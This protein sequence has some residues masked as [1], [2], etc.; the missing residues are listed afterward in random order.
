VLVVV[1]AALA[2]ALAVGWTLGLQIATLAHELPRY[3]ANITKKI[4][5]IKAVQ[6]GSLKDVQDSAN[7]VMKE[8]QKGG[9]GAGLKDQPVP[10]TVVPSGVIQWLPGIPRLTASMG[11]VILLVVF[12]LIRRLRL[13]SR[14]IV[15]LGHS[16]LT[17]TT[18]A[19]DEAGSRIS[20]YLLMQALM[21]GSLGATLA[22]T[23]QDAAARHEARWAGSTPHRAGHRDVAQLAPVA[24]AAQQQAAPAHVAAADEL[25]GK[26]QARPEDVLEQIDVLTRGNA[27]QQH[28]LAV[29][30]GDARRDRPGITQQRL[31]VAPLTQV[32]GNRRPAPEHVEPYVGFGKTE[33]CSRRDD[34]H[35]RRA[36]RRPRVGAC[37]LELAT[38]V[39]SAEEAEDLA[40]RRSRRS[41]ERARQIEASAWVE[42]QA[43]TPPSA[44]GGGEEKYPA[45]HPCRHRRRAGS[46]WRVRA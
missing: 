14:L 9:D 27:P 7:A 24:R 6:R 35:A 22:L 42:E 31:R 15:V 40:E 2:V 30:V 1:G 45:F 23:P 12:M 36:V 26:D 21:N 29:V 5:D 32:D 4:G 25:R 13:R 41:A 8:L 16:R 28:H 34:E 20:R 3:R 11:F 33:P 39:E 38:E 17:V 44:R 18:K 43:R 19:L 46:V 37:V 10:V